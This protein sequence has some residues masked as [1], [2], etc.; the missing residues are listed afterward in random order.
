MANEELKLISARL[1]KET[2]AKIDE[3]VRKH[4]Y[5]KRNTVINMILWAVMN[6]FD[7]RDIY[8]MVRRNHFRQQPVHCGYTI[9]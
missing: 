2:L 4:T 5:W 1:D 7:E 6:D 3:F 8:D 9:E